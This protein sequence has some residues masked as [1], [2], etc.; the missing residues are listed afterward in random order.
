ML[1]EAKNQVDTQLETSRIDLDSRLNALQEQS[2]AFV[3]EEKLEAR[4]TAVKVD[5]QNS[6]GKLMGDMSSRITLLENQSGDKIT[7]G[8]VEDHLN[9]V[10]AQFHSAVN[11]FGENL[12]NRMIRVE[13]ESQA[14]VSYSEME[15]RIDTTYICRR[16]F[17]R[18]HVP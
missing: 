7:H 5:L 11:Q 6:Y 16:N 3:T 10:Q 4:L 1:E 13:N 14:R 9:T 8:Q 15:N 12:N 18:Q 2:Q 17:R